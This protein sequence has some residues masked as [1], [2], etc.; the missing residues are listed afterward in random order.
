MQII[1]YY[2]GIIESDTRFIASDID[3]IASDSVFIAS[4]TCFIVSDSNFIASDNRFVGFDIAFCAS[5]RGRTLLDME[6]CFF[7]PKMGLKESLFVRLI[8]ILVLI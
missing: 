5:R 1:A 4:D 8:K 6:K 7:T 2:V 3:F